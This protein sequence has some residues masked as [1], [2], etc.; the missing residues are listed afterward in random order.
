MKTLAKAALCI[1]VIV[2]GHVQNIQNKKQ[3][4][5]AD[6]PQL[7]LHTRCKINRS[8]SDPPTSSLQEV[9]AV[10]Q[11]TQSCWRLDPRILAH[12][13]VASHSLRLLGQSTPKR[14]QLLRFYLPVGWFGRCCSG[15]QQ[16]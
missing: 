8:A 7:M 9:L 4:E 13:F 2:N 16:R 1:R 14:D 6:T 10:V 11:A 3:K 15:Q 12:F 5:K